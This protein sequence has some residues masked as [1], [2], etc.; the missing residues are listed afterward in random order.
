MAGRKYSNVKGAV[1]PSFMPNKDIK[2]LTKV[3]GSIP[4]RTP[5]EEKVIKD[6]N[7]KRRAMNLKEITD[8]KLVVSNK[9]REMARRKAHAEK[10]FPKAAAKAKKAMK[11]KGSG[12]RSTTKFHRPS[13]VGSAAG[14]GL[15]GRGGA[16][17]LKL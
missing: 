6:R 12:S 10:L 11:T 1:G 9:A 15:G 3:L 14:A 8:K 7:A 16:R 5:T 4:K 13:S 2:T 17:K